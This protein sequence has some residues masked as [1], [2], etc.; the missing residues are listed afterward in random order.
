MCRCWIN[1]SPYTIVLI[2][3]VCASMVLNLIFLC[4]ILRVLLIKLRAGPRVG[5]SRPS[6]T[7]LQVCCYRLQLTHKFQRKDILIICVYWAR[8]IHS[9]LLDATQ[10]KMLT[11]PLTE[12]QILV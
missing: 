1:E 4:N 10:F 2:I 3:P 9:L 6:S 8:N 7:L 5:S 11:V 12:L